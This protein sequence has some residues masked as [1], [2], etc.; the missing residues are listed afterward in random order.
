MSAY[1]ETES[2]KRKLKWGHWVHPNPMGTGAPLRGGNLGARQGQGEE[3]KRRQGE[4][5]SQAKERSTDR[6]PPRSSEGAELGD[7]LIQTSSLP[8]LR[9]I[10]FCCLSHQLP[11]PQEMSTYRPTPLLLD[12]QSLDLR[13]VHGAHTFGHPLQLSIR[14]SHL[15]PSLC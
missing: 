6:S 7:I 14:I 5:H 4:G 2:L 10:H 1:L 12:S 8:E 11:Q 3:D 9:E 13:E 15:Q